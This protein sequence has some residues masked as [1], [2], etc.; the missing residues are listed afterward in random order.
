MNRKQRRRAFKARIKVVPC[1]RDPREIFGEQT[2]EQIL[3][4]RQT[5]LQD[6]LQRT[7]SERKKQEIQ[8]D[9]KLGDD[10]LRRMFRGDIRPDD[11]DGFMQV[12]LR[13]II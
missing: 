2:L 8:L 12:R 4:E 9:W 11:L 1:P 5:V 3:S 13:P 6:I 7:T 10:K